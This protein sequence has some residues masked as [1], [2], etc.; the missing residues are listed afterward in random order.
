MQ[1]V[2][3][4]F[5][6]FFSVITMLIVGAASGGYAVAADDLSGSGVQDLG[7]GGGNIVGG[8]MSMT[9]T[10][11]IQDA[12]W[13]LK[14]INKTIVEMKFTGTPIDQILRNASFNKSDSI[15]VKFYSVGQRPLKA[16]VKTQFNL[17]TSATPQAIELE[18]DTVLGAMDTCLCLDKDGDF[19]PG[20]LPGT[21]NV[22]N[23][24]PLMIRVNAVDSGTNKPLIYAVNGKKDSS[25]GKPFIIPQLDKGTILVRMGRAAAE[26]D[27]QTGQYYILPEPEEQ[28]CQR[29]IMQVEQTV[30]DRFS[31]KE[32][33][34]SFTRVERMAMEDMRIGMEASGLFGI[35][36]KHAINAQ[37]NI[38]T[39]EGIWYRAGKD[40]ELGRWEVVTD[41]AGKPVDDGTNQV[42]EL[43]I[44]EGDLVDLV[45][46]IIEGAG[47]GSRTK[48]VFVDKTIYAALCKIKTVNRVRI[49]EPEKN[50]NGWGLDFQSFE[51]MG[52]KL[53]FYRHDLFNAWGFNGKAFCLDPEYLDKWVF[54]NWERKEY[55]LTKLFISNSNAVTM[56]EFSCW[57][58][59]FP[60]AH[61]RITIPE[62][63]V[64]PKA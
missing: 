26:K 35:K 31:K 52:T 58:L 37:G 61:A 62:Y 17:M 57:T 32:V 46:Q 22:D 5:K 23:T 11:Q 8:A 60:D 10:E 40:I 39:C 15:T 12:E 1:K 38:Y 14:Q 44:T 42:Q 21:D 56:Q 55:D 34:W 24:R 59:G 9:K 36:S 30:Y 29:F 64:I 18:N 33:D 4:F 3:H 49:F 48:L 6:F 25:T 19:I 54:Q 41:A 43:V 47:N 7:N 51:S 50:F 13:Y 53:L 16:V 28:Y 45:D 27:V 20:Y 63:K 2:K